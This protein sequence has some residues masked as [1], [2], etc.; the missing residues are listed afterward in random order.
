MKISKIIGIGSA[1]TLVAV[2]GLSLVA[3]TFAID[4]D[5]AGDLANT[6][7]GTI[8]AAENVAV[9]TATSLTLEVGL[10]GL[11][12]NVDATGSE[13]ALGSYTTLPSA[14]AVTA[15]GIGTQVDGYSHIKVE[16]NDGS[17][18]TA[19]IMMC[20]ASASA[21]FSAVSGCTAGQNLASSSSSTYIAPVTDN[22]A[23]LTGAAGA[24]VGGYWGYRTSYTLSGGSAASAPTG[25][26]RQVPAFTASS[27]YGN[28][29]IDTSA[30]GVG[31]AN[32]NYSAVTNNV[33]EGGKTYNNYVI[34]TAVAK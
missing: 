19:Y 22:S 12:S 10:G 4:D 5:S 21:P 1:L 28:I 32:L 3:P 14:M 34:Y 7:P 24:N 26:F 6:T 18:Y 8:A 17:G 16:S 25:N 27:P 20:T 2:A 15:S 29:L 9:T 31:V 23:T 11:V 13:T 33:L 30:P